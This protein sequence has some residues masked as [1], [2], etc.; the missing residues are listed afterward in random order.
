VELTATRIPQ[1]VGRNPA[2]LALG[3][4]APVS[5]RHFEAPARWVDRDTRA[6]RVADGV[7]LRGEWKRPVMCVIRE[8]C[9]R[10]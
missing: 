5:V 8:C 2:N 6:R 10:V 7:R 3:L 9:H 4:M 1:L